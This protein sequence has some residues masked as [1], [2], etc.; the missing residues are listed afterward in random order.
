MV[1]R[2]VIVSKGRV[3]A[4]P[5]VELDGPQSVTDDNLADMERDHIIRVLQETKGVL[6][7]RMGLPAGWVSSARHCSRC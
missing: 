4:A 2:M 3:L 7:E 5:P 1:E 6:P